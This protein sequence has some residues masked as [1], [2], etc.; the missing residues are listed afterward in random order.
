MVQWEQP[1]PGLVRPVRLDPSGVRGP[2]RGQARN[3][4]RYRRSSFGFYVPATADRG[5]V[6]QRIVEA[7]AASGPGT[8]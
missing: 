6:E 5:N 4:S 1:R 8:R 7:A 2:T 3:R